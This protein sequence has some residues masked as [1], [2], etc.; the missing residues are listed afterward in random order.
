MF[1]SFR[2]LFLCVPF[3]SIAFLS[4]G[5][6]LR[7][8]TRVA[9]PLPAP[10]NSTTG[11]CWKVDITFSAG[12]PD[13]VDYKIVPDPSTSKCKYSGA[14]KN[15]LQICQGDI[16]NWE[17]HTDIKTAHMV[18]SQSDSI[19]ADITASSKPRLEADE[20]TQ[21]SNPGVNANVKP[22]TY[23]Y[24]VAAYDRNDGVKHLYVNDPKIIVGGNLSLVERVS[25]LADK[26]TE[27][28]PIV[29]EDP[30]VKNKKK[31]EQ[32]LKKVIDILT[33]LKDSLKR[34]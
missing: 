22:G 17:I 11:Q 6:L 33:N 25:Q 24:C 1:S 13:T 18:I 14:G 21:T 4:L 5:A 34:K 10:C 20:G 19:L 2:K 7:S 30:M 29:K 3:L 32:D 9:T 26:S 23:E 8:S 12:N 28:I 15:D 27:L 31:A 16:V